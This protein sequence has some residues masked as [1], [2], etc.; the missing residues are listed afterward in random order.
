MSEAQTLFGF[1]DNN[2]WR[3]NSMSVTATTIQ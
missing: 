2:Q 1:G 3:N